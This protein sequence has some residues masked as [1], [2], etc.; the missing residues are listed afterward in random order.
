MSDLPEL[1]KTS[2]RAEFKRRRNAL[3]PMQRATYSK[4]I[5]RKLLAL[6]DVI[7]ATNCFVYISCGTEVATRELID[8]MLSQN[9]TLAVP[10]IE[11]TKEMRAVTFRSWKDCE[12]KELGILTPISSTPCDVKFDI[13]ITPGLA[14][15]RA[16]TR[17][18][19]GAGYYDKWFSKHPVVRKIAVAFDC[20]LA[21]L[22]P[23][24][25]YDIPVDLIVTEREVIEPAAK[26]P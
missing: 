4:L 25:P 18:G 24:D 22:L 5:C 7:V 14:F 23:Q 15:T 10:K 12:P 26:Q 20:Q 2:L 6:P 8:E 19:F 9:K 3:T 13:S 16:G 17:L 21:E 1:T 11:P